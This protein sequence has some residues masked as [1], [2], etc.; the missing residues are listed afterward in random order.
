MELSGPS[1]LNE[2][3]QNSKALLVWQRRTF[4]Q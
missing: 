1:E 3:R 2:G 4:N